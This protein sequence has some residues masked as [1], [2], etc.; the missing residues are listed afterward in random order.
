MRTLLS[1]W[2]LDVALV[3][4][5]TSGMVLLNGWIRKRTLKAYRFLRR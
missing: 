1:L 3:L 4:T 2:L 5:L